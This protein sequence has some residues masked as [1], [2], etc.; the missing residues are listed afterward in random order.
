MR[1]HL[2]TQ[3]LNEEAQ[4]GFFFRHYDPWVERYIVYDDGS[5]DGTLDILARH[6]RVEVRRFRR[7]VPDSFVASAQRLHDTAWKESRGRAD[8][9]VIT[10]IDEHLHHPDLPGYL[11]RC[12]AAGVSMVPA[13]GYQ[14]VA[15]EF[16]P[17]DTTLCQALT[18]G[19]AFKGMNKLS[20][21]APD[22]LRETR[23]A[24]GRHAATPTGDLVCP[25]RD[26]LLLLHYKY[27]GLDYLVR[28]QAMLSAGL[29]ARDMERG[30]GRQYT[31]PEAENA[32]RFERL[33][34][35]AIDTAAPG[36]DHHDWNPTPRWWREEGVCRFAPVA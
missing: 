20:L 2:Y 6:G 30:W 16:P 3:S 18:W 26:E 12:Q 17:P 5:T 23:F 21:F 10:A 33:R 9:V 22:R 11:A 34:K 15:T 7:V 35:R 13:L 36:L 8:W 31:L 19:T 32:T 14:M 27:L 1:V 24:P 4:L 25:E 28:R 29:G